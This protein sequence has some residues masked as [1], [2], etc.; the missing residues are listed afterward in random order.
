M[1]KVIL[2]FV[3][4]IAIVLLINS[5]EFAF[6]QLGTMNIHYRGEVSPNYNEKPPTISF[7]LSNGTSMEP[8]FNSTINLDTAS[9]FTLIVTAVDGVSPKGIGVR[10]KEVSYKNSWSGNQT[11]IYKFNYDITNFDLY[12]KQT[13]NGTE[14]IKDYTLTLINIPTGHQTIEFT[15]TAIGI[16][17]D[18]DYR[19]FTK[20]SI[21]TLD[22]KV[23]DSATNPI[24]SPSVPEFSWLTILPILLTTTIALA[25]VGK[26]LQRNV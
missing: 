7:K 23:N 19:S 6:A 2:I 18:G 11:I 10:L 3:L 9:N 8:T 15:V 13:W 20:S 12:T 24:S 21:V 16:Y 26:R 4:I 1:K 14:S 5:V 22:L 25:I 17:L